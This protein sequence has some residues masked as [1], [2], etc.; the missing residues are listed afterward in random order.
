MPELYAPHRPRSEDTTS[1]PARLRFRAL[2]EQRMVQSGF[3][4][5]GGE[6][7]GDLEGIGP[8]GFEPILRLGKAR[9]RDQLLGLG[10]LLDRA[11]GADPP[12]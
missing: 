8:G 2:D 12:A 1:T 4:G 9:R 6:H 3:A 10:D 11:R 7:P 5:Q